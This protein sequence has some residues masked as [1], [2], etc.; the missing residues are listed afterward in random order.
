MAARR[1]APC[2]SGHVRKP[3]WSQ[4]AHRGHQDQGLYYTLQRATPRRIAAGGPGPSATRWRP[5]PNA[6]ASTRG[7]HRQHL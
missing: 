1:V 5:A 7:T 3:D 2:P 4:S 6:P